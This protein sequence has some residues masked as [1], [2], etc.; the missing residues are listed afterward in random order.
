MA[1]E[2]FEA[3]LWAWVEEVYRRRAPQPTNHNPLLTAA[4]PATWRG[5]HAAP[6]TREYRELFYPRQPPQHPQPHVSHQHHRQQP[7]PRHVH[8]DKPRQHRRHV[9]Q[10]SAYPQR[11]KLSSPTPPE[12]SRR[13]RDVV[14]AA[15]IHHRTVFMFK[16][17]P[18]KAILKT[19]K[20]IDEAFSR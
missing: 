1:G 8:G 11:D 4:G 19:V 15:I 7:Q 17:F 18:K 5:L 13:N 16:H 10:L 9:P 3:E 14:T 6:E 12:S 2:T 20:V